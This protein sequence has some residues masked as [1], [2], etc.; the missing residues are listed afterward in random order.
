M[1]IRRSRKD[2][3]LTVLAIAPEVSYEGEKKDARCGHFSDV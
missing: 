2:G 1:L 3:D